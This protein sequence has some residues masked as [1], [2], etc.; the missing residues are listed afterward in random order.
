MD[1]ELHRFK[2]AINLTEFA[3]SQGYELDRKESSRHSATMRHPNGDKVI[4]ARQEGGGDWIYFSVRNDRDNGSII[5]FAQHREGGSLGQVRKTL[6]AW[7]GDTRP[8]P[9]LPHYVAD[10][11]PISRDRAGVLAAWERASPCA[12]LPYLA[13]RGITAD[14]LALPRFAGRVR[15]DARQNALFPHY[16]HGGLCGYEIKNA[17]FTGFAPQGTKGLWYS[18]A[19]STDGELVLVESA[20]DAYSYHALQGGQWSRYMS[21]GGTLNPEQPTLLRAA[22]ERLAAGA[23]VMLAF[24]HDEGGE[25]LAEQVRA[26][27]PAG[28]EVRRVLPPVGE[29]KD[30]NEALQ[31]RLGLT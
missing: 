1:S 29:G 13:G 2:T 31:R 9:P 22:M 27:A 3:A 4:I 14:L 24:D 26:L 7:L 11:L 28:R 30:W 20:I 8:R 23:V 21:T 5:D 25:A 19:H 16:D 6:R 10:L 18:V 12:G 15:V 17:G